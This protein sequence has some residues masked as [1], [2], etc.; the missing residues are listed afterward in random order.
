MFRTFL[1]L[2]P[3]GWFF[4]SIPCYFVP[5][6][7]LFVELLKLQGEQFVQRHAANARLDIVLD[8]VSVDLVERRPHLDLSVAFISDIH[9]VAHGVFPRSGCI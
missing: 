9:P 5:A 4:A 2:N 1:G 6:Q 3:F 7:Q 8:V